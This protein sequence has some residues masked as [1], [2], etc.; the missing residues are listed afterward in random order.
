M[1]HA[2]RRIR[3]RH[4]HASTACRWHTPDEALGRRNPAP[5]RLHRAAAP[6]GHRRRPAERRRPGARAGRDQRSRRHGHRGAARARAAAA[7]AHRTRPAGATMPPT[8][9]RYAVGERAQVRH[10]LF[11]VTPGVDVN[12]LRQRAEACLLDLRCHDARRRRTA[13]PRWRAAAVQ[14]PQRRAGRRARLAHADDCAPEF[15]RELFGHAEVGVLPRLVHSRFGLHV[16]EVLAREPGA[17]P[18]FEAVRAARRAGAA[19]AG[20]RHRAAPVPAAAGR[21]GRASKAS[22]ST[23]PTTPLVQ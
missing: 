10:V 6:G 18:A 20:L 8:R 12:A 4:A 2:A 11:A 7:R 16:V 21:P 23:P 9:P 17:Q 19:P 3:P 1:N 5:A 15:A 22:T 13:S 14:L